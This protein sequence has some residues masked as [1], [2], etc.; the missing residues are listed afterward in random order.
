VKRERERESVCVCVCIVLSGR[1][2]STRSPTDAVCQTDVERGRGYGKQDGC[3]RCADRVR[4]VGR[5]ELGIGVEAFVTERVFCAEKEG[6]GTVA[7][8][9]K[10]FGDLKGTVVETGRET[11]HP[12][13]RKW[14]EDVEVIAMDM[15]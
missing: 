5:S 10:H 14:S 2:G 11:G 15:P 4:T 8:L 12:C 13:I 9:S 3:N 7:S 6:I 1:T